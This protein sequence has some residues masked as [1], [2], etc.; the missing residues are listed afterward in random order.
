MGERSAE[1][2]VVVG[3]IPTGPIMPRIRDLRNDDGRYREVLRRRFLA[4]L[5]PELEKG[6]SLYETFVRKKKML[7]DLR[8][9]RNRLGKEFSRTKNPG[10]VEKVRE[11]K[12]MIESIEKEVSGL[13]EEMRRIELVL[14]NWLH[15]RVPIGKDDARNVPIK[16][17]GTP[18]VLPENE[19]Q[20]KGAFPDVK[21]VL[22]GG[23]LHHAD[24]VQ[25]FDLVDLESAGKLAG[26][27]FYIE[28]G[29]LAT[30]DLAFTLWAFN[31]FVKAG[32]RPIIPP[33]LMR[34]SVEERIAYFT[35]F[36]DSIYELKNDGLILIP[37]SEHPLVALFEN[38]LFNEDELPLRLVAFTHAFRREAGAHGKDTK[39][40]FRVHQF[41][42]IELHSMTTL[43]GD[44][45][46]LD[47]LRETIENLVKELNI[48]YR[49]VLNSSGDMDK[50]AYLQMDLEGWFPAQNTFRELHSLATMKTWVSEKLN[51]K[52]LRGSEKEFVA[53][54]YATGFAVQRTLLAMF[55]NN[56]DPDSEVIRIPRVLQPYCGFSEIELHS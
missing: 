52:V 4:G 1:D 21:Y 18:R 36:E 11:I 14:P 23:L 51:I 54:L 53:N 46:E 44:E 20:F 30:L 24:L 49:I 41:G 38:R 29:K 48:P 31:E 42:K 2:R 25:K 5:V 56:Y 13:E 15:D 22:K 50:R 28:K 10:L 37:T 47:F 8:A 12:K 55:V 3:S 32:F 45:K 34:R 35:A 9:E 6:I 40:I 43:D 19:L 27:R 26:A 17:A 33:E 16:Y 39:G 7:D